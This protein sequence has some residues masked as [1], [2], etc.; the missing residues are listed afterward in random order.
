[1]I[2]F[3]VVSLIFP[4][5]HHEPR[6]VEAVPSFSNLNPSADAGKSY[7]AESQKTFAHTH[8]SFRGRGEA[9]PSESYSETAGVRGQM[10][11]MK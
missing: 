7:K 8:S 5:Y 1:M 10:R 6:G 4:N 2:P 9:I 11:G 3:L